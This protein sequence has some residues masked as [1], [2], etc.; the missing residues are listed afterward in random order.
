MKS[1]RSLEFDA[2][3]FEDLVWWIEKDRSKA[4]PEARDI[5]TKRVIRGSFNSGVN[6]KLQEMNLA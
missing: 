2:A 4:L 1:A 3:A 6:I 5:K